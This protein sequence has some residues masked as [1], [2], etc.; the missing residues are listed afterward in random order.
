MGPRD[1]RERQKELLRQEILDA[2]RELFVKEGYEN[3]SMRRIAEK[4]EYS[5]TT[6]YLYFQDKADL[7]NNICEETFMKLIEKMNSITVT[8]NDPV[9]ALKQGC[10]AYV[11]FGLEYPNHYRV[12]FINH[13]EQGKEP[14]HYLREGL[15]GMKAFDCLRRAV[16]ECVRQNKFRETDVE[17]IS[18]AL[19]AAGHGVVSLMIVKKHFPW[20]DKDRLIDLSINAIIDGL[21][22]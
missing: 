5:P 22:A 16:A 18:Q 19:W 8:S 6:I 17:M 3:V 1:R 9:E 7:L 11:E 14:E 21:R 10:R 15:S 12:T 13:P 2:A 4:I 20:V